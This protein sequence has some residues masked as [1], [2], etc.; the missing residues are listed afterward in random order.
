M[1]LH[2]LQRVVGQQRHQRSRP[3]LSALHMAAE[4]WATPSPDITLA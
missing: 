1:H 4:A 3:L 2:R